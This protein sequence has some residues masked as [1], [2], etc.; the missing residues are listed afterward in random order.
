[1]QPSQEA[2]DN[3]DIA[4]CHNCD[5]EHYTWDMNYDNGFYYCYCCS[6]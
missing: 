5:H 1:M 3:D 6:N 4:Y 2:Y